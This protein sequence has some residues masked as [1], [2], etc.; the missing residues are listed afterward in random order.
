MRNKYPG[1]CY[2]CGKDVPVGFGF[3]E[4]VHDHSQIGKWRIKCV[5]CT[6]GRDVKDTD[7]EVV[8]AVMALKNKVV[9]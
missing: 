1:V 4:K 3:F 7:K 9:G 5:K 2:V 8:R 6:D